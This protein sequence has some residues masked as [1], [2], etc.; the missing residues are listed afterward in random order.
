M[1]VNYGMDKV[2][3]PTPV[4]VNS[5]IRAKR[6]LVAAELKNPT[7]IQVKYKI[8]VEIENEPKPCCVAEW[9]FRV[10]YG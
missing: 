8:T 4:K 10:N 5:K 3:F 9:L 7:S 2:R 6:E 1:G